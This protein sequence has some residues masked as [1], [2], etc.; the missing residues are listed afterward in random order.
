LAIKET[1][2]GDPCIPIDAHVVDVSH[3]AGS[4]LSPSFELMDAWSG[5]DIPWKEF[6][7]RYL[8]EISSRPLANELMK[9]IIE[10]SQK[11]DIWILCE[12]KEYPCHR[13]LIKYL[14]ERVHFERGLMESF[15]DYVEEYQR[16]KNKRRSQIISGH[17]RPL[18]LP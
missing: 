9:Q 2:I 13:Y 15:D 14:V 12:E 4:P 5:D 6:V 3:R 1:Y 11:M 10:S 18:L 16:F 17:S 7:E 8:E